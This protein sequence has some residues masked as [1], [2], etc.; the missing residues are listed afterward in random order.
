MYHFFTSP[1][2]ISDRD[3]Y[4]SGDDFNHIKNVLR[5]RVGEVISVND[6][7]SDR[8][9]RCHLEGYE[10][11][12]AHFRLDFIK[13]SDVEL[14]VRIHLFQCIPKGDKMELIIQKAVE[15][16]VYEIIPVASARCVTRIDPKKEEKKLER[17]NKIS[18]SAAEQSK[19]AIIPEVKNIMP[20]K[21]AVEYSKCLD[22]SGLAYELEEGSLST[23]GFLT[24]I[25]EGTDVG[26]FIGP[27]GGIDEKEAGYAV[28]SGITSFSLG[29]RILRTETAALV[30]LSWLVYKFEILS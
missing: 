4:I 25:K 9:Y 11:N 7:I 27:E 18:C 19:R 20:F 13:E 2:N 16:G 15:L 23:T 8:E 22:I 3:I 17:W 5:M 14:P 12:R 21:G 10:E 30:F 28:S 29:K 26:V 24:G 1:E 6:G